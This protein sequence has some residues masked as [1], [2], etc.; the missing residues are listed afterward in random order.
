MRDIKIANEKFNIKDLCVRNFGGGFAKLLGALLQGDLQLR[1]EGLP[2]IVV[3]ARRRCRSP[4]LPLA[5]AA[6]TNGSEKAA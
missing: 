3:A 2:I 1:L 5:V 6:D 4:S